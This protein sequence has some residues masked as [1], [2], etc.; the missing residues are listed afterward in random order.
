[1]TIAPFLAF[2]ISA[3]W[4]SFVASAPA[5]EPTRVQS[6]PKFPLKP[7]ANHRYLVDQD[8]VPLLLVGDSPQSIIGNLTVAQAARYMRNRADHGINA[9]W[10]NLLC[11]DA[12]A[13]R[14]DGKTVDGLS[15]FDVPGDLSTPNQQ[16][17]ERAKAIVAL[18]AANH[19]VVFLDPI[20]TAGWLSILRVNGTERGFAYGEFLGKTFE[21]FPN[22]VW[23]YGNDFQ[24]WE[25][26]NDDALLQSVAAGIRSVDRTH[27]A[28]VE[29]NYLTSGSLD[30]PTWRPLID[31]DAA[32]TYYPTYAQVLT[33][34]NRSEAMPVFLV[35][36]NYEFERGE[37]G[38]PL[39]L[40]RQTYWSVLSGATGLLYGSSYSW[41]FLPGWE[42][43]LDSVGVRELQIMK[44]FFERYAWE[45]LVPDQ[46]HNAVVAGFGTYLSKG[47]IVTDTYATAAKA[48][49][50]SLLMAYLPT[51][52]SIV[53]DMAQLRGPMVAQW[54]DPTTGALH[55]DDNKTLPATGRATFT[56]PG[57][58]G[59]GD[60]D[61]VLVISGPAKATAPQT[62]P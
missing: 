23:L 41:Q 53:V 15:P 14:Q 34:Y 10:I 21:S 42:S 45:S 11:N 27:I 35:E 4:L 55:D 19:Q 13:C 47:S 51:L 24:S 33:E 6:G 26:P 17:F 30:D 31:F 54:F 2:A 29:L 8:N 32:Y 46:G 44:N 38:S 12:T 58:N 25:N 60:E 28:T 5:E 1:M 40:R 16:Y 49:D 48:A 62:E 18:S 39:N 7:S 57:K 59:S 56:P 61:W 50:G 22:V 43:R 36:G 20:E 37:A 3:A 9:L 52:R